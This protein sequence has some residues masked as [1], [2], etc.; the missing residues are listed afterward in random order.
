MS[1]GLNALPA[2]QHR[3]STTVLLFAGAA[4]G[5]IAL[6]LATNGKAPVPKIWGQLR[7]FS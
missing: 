4:V 1:L 3:R 6:H 7:N 5:I 2:Q